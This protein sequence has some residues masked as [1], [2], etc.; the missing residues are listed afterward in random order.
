MEII[1]LEKENFCWIFTNWWKTFFIFLASNIWVWKEI[2]NDVP[3][4]WEERKSFFFL[5]NWHAF[6]EFDASISFVPNTFIRLL[7]T[8]RNDGMFWTLSAVIH[9]LPS[10]C[11]FVS[12]IEELWIFFRWMSDF[13]VELKSLKEIWGWVKQYF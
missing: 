3:E 8:N 6:I 7:S 4:E 5:S 9:L 13:G 2:N 10:C 12:Q 11:Q 1:W